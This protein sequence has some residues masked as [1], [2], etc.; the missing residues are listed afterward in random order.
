MPSPAFFATIRFGC[1]LETDGAANQP[2]AIPG[3]DQLARQAAPAMAIST[4]MIVGFPGEKETDFIETRTFIQEIGF[5]S[6]HVFAFS[7]RPGTPAYQMPDRILPAVIKQRSKDLRSDFAKM[8][9]DYQARYVGKKLKIL[10]ET[11]Q[12]VE[13]D[14]WHLSGLSDNYLRVAAFHPDDRWN[15]IDEVIVEKIGTTGLYAVFPE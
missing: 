1:D 15:Q 8:Q 10:W 7:A 6:G 9:M 2:E 5:A 13:D 14:R 4:D 12:R 11:S 3:I